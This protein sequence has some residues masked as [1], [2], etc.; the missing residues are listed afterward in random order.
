MLA[1]QKNDV[2]IHTESGSAFGQGKSRRSTVDAAI[3]FV[4]D[5]LKKS[6]ENGADL[7]SQ[8]FAYRLQNE[9]DA[10]ANK[11]HF[12]NHES[13][14]RSLLGLFDRDYRYMSDD[15]S[16]CLLNLIQSRCIDVDKVDEIRT[17]LYQ[18]F[19]IRDYASVLNAGSDYLRE[20][21]NGQYNHEASLALLAVKMY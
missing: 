2:K 12:L 14:V 20:V 16:G 18:S 7:A 21:R 19:L 5:N 8:E 6:H 1:L 17:G 11:D 15:D 10:C 13:N 4:K 9:L 3:S